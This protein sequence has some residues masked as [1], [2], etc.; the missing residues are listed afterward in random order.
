MVTRLQRARRLRV[1]MEAREES[2]WNL[3][4]AGLAEDA[5][6]ACDED[7]RAELVQEH[8]ELL[9]LRRRTPEQERA[10]AKAA[11]EI[12]RTAARMDQASAADR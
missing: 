12:T 1:R 3:A 7:D 11:A 9:A 2:K 10:N 5:A 8:A 6:Q 4:L